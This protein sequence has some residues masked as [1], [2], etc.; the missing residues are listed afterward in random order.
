MAHMR[1]TVSFCAAF[2]AAVAT[3]RCDS[4]SAPIAP[5]D[6]G[7]VSSGGGGAQPDAGTSIGGGGQPDAGSGGG[8]GQPDAGGAVAGHDECA[9]LGPGTVGQP[10]ASVAIPATDYE[11]WF[12]GATDGSGTVALMMTDDNFEP[13]LRIRLFH[14][15]GAERGAYRSA[16]VTLGEAIVGQLQGVVVS[17]Y[18]TVHA[19]GEL[20]A[21]D[22]N[23]SVMATTEF[24][25]IPWW[26][27]A[28]DPLGGIVL[29]QRQHMPPP[30]VVASYD[31]RLN[32]RFRTQLSST[33]RVLELGVD[34]QGNSLVLL[35]ATDRYGSGKVG[36]I[37]IDHSGNAG[38][39]FL[40]LE[41]VP[42]PPYLF[43]TPR[44]GN[45]FFAARNPGPPTTAAWIGQFD[46][47]G[48]GTAPPDWLTARP[49]TRLPVV[50][51][52]RAYA[53]IHPA[54]LDAVCHADIEVVA[55]S[56]K[57]CGTAAFPADQSGQF[58]AGGLFVGS[59]GTIVGGRAEDASPGS[60]TF[61]FRWWTGFLH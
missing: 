30:S 32:L 8:G 3:V 54:R 20:A 31:E 57:S 40:A 11:N 55:P 41:N 29:V 49:V 9:G 13:S 45:G 47:M 27:I 33:E 28:N 52:G 58:C 48:E 39:E 21:L 36:G 35:D 25:G 1:N 43:L 61:T 53:V 60:R 12:P 56:G 7:T 50:R 6:A 18:D 16:Q 4:R 14:P 23:G 42:S 59:D 19:R 44:V 37:W 34:R 26:P 22:E 51:N 17:Y 15:S 10:S 2:L 24:E 46:A 38:A 5:T